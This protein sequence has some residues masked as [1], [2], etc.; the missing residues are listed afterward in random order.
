MKKRNPFHKR[1]FAGVECI[2]R[3]QRSLFFIL[4]FGVFSRVVRDDLTKGL[5]R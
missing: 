5:R 4:V 3:Y 2:R 1:F